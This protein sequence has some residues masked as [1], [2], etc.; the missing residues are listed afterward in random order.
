[1][2][3]EGTTNA[4]VVSGRYITEKKE[5]Q[6]RATEKY[7]VVNISEYECARSVNEEGVECPPGKDR[8]PPGGPAAPTQ[9]ARRC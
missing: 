2:E 3:N 5:E 8:L 9:G 6:S 7:K 4:S 1:M